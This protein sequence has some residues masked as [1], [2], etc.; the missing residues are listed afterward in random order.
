MAFSMRLVRGST[1]LIL[2]LALCG[3]N[4]AGGERTVS[5]LTS[6][7]LRFALTTASREELQQPAHQKCTE[8]QPNQTCSLRPAPQRHPSATPPPVPRH[9]DA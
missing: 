3:C 1:L 4:Q 2:T 9:V 7:I 8:A 5:L 6:R